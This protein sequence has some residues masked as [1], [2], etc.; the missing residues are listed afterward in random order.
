LKFYP[1]TWQSPSNIVI[2]YDDNDGEAWNGIAYKKDQEQDNLLRLALGVLEKASV[3]M[4]VG[5]L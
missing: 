5:E 2:S 4:L 1:K 3:E